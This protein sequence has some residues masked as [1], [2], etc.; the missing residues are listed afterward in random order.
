MFS[1][2]DAGR[3]VLFDC[4]EKQPL[5]DIR[6]ERSKVFRFPPETANLSLDVQIV[7]MPSKNISPQ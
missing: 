2:K 6:F 1:A 3:L 4:F 7:Q 5:R